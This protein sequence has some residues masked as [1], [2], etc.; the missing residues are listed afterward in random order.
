VSGLVGGVVGQRVASL[1]SP[2]ATR[3][4]WAR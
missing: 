4:G 1:W 3:S 2:G